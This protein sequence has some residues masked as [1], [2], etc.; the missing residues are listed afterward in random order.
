MGI[1]D[2][3]VFIAA[4]P[5]NRGPAEDLHEM[6]DLAQAIEELGY[7][8]LFTASRHFSSGYA[9]V[10]SPLVLFAAVAERTRTLEFGPSV[11]TLPLENIHRLAEDFAVLDAISGGRAVLGVGSGDDPPAFAAMG[12]EF[13]ERA[14]MLSQTIERFLDILQGGD[15]GAGMTLY[16]PIEN[17]LDKVALGAQSARGAAWAASLGIGLQQ[18]RS[19]PNSWDPTVSQVR[20]AEA[21][22]AVHPTGRISTARNAWV[23]TADD[24]E[25]WEGIRRHDEFLKSRGLSGMPEDP[26]EALRKLNVR[27]GTPE[28]LAIDLKGC[29][30]SIKPD[31]LLITPDPGGLEAS[32]RLK[33]LTALAEAFGLGGT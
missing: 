26:K 3:G 25:L 33:R 12:V 23:G 9:A 7:R 8:S 15:A 24:P 2:I 28:G 11:V 14:G 22:R 19:E 31:E 4:E 17:A 16:P 27:I 18:G 6:I 13:D 32:D 10:P 29:V 21:Y 1:M 30:A 20:A 5:H